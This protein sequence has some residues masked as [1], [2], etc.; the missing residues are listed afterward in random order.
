MGLIILF[1]LEAKPIYQCSW[2]REITSH[3]TL[4]HIM[5]CLVGLQQSSPHSSFRRHHGVNPPRA[6]DPHPNSMFFKNL[7][8]PQNQSPHICK[9]REPHPTPKLINN[10]SFQCIHFFWPEENRPKIFSK[11]LQILMNSHESVMYSI[12]SARRYTVCSLC[13][14]CLFFSL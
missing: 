3:C 1:N 12:S 8:G 10:C 11:T 2:H 4:E 6:P 14:L 5:C 7:R 13:V 9:N